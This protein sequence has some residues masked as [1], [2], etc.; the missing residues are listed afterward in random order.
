[1]RHRAKTQP[2]EP[3]IVVVVS[4]PA[5]LAGYTELW[6]ELAANAV[7][8]NPY[9][10]PWMLLPALSAFGAGEKLRIALVLSQ[11]KGP[12]RKGLESVMIGL[13]PLHIA[14]P[15][16]YLPMTRLRMWRHDY[17][18]LCAPLVHSDYG[19]ETV[20]SFFDWFAE[21][22]EVSGPLDLERLPGDGQ[23]HQLLLDEVARRG[24]VSEVRDR[25]TRAVLRPNCS[26]DDYISRAL[27]GKK[28]KELRRQSRKLGEVGPVEFSSLSDRPAD[29][30]DDWLDQFVALEASGWKGEEQT[31]IASN[32]AHHEFFVTVA[33]EAARR[34][35]LQISRLTAGDQ[36]IAAKLNFV[37]PPGAF[38]FRITFDESYARYSPGV[39]LELDAIERFCES[40]LEFMD[41]CAARNHPMIDHLWTDKRTIEHL[42]VSASRVGD[43]VLS[44]LPLARFARR[45]LKFGKE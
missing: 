33:R 10:E 19:R 38:A 41:S 9:Y 31:A 14:G 28:R 17:S 16:R 37:S 1:M 4:D 23:L 44:V 21:Q 27:S 35:Q 24:W 34:G 15:S 45:A 5:E 43:L 29:E 3:P 13:F 42:L 7:E 26:A 40:D 6:E 18:F 32:P 12:P 8:P 25:F 20:L 39:L 22:T 30:I 36:L 11:P 2:G